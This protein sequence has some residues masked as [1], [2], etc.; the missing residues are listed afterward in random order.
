M[1]I[2]ATVAAS[3]VAITTILS[4]C[5]TPQESAMNA[6]MT[7]QSQ[8]FRPGTQRYN[9]CVGATYQANRVQAQQ[10]ENQAAGLAAAGII[11]GVLVGAAV[12]DH[13]HR[14]YYGRPYYRRCYRC[15]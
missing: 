12:S 6:E 11:G 7:C 9:R 1:R 3:L 2:R 15:W 13:H 14:G 10:A 5:Q 8:G 4:S